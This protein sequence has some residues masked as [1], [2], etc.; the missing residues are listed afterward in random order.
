MGGHGRRPKG[1]INECNY[2]PSTSDL[3]RMI[4]NLKLSDSDRERNNGKA[5]TSVINIIDDV[6][7]KNRR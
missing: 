4:E 1:E 7:V 2:F 6:N 5:F 3:T